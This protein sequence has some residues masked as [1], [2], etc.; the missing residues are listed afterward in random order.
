MVDIK[1]ACKRV[2]QM[3][4]EQQC[5]IDKGL[6][7]ADIPFNSVIEVFESNGTRTETK[8]CVLKRYVN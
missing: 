3:P 7:L 4:D 8:I 1:K 5:A 6:R 2:G